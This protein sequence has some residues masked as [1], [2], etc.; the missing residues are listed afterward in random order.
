MLRFNQSYGYSKKYQDLSPVPAQQQLVQHRQQ[1]NDK[2]K[3]LCSEN[4]K[5]RRYVNNY[6]LAALKWLAAFF[7]L[8]TNTSFNLIS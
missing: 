2:T 6:I 8:D 1:I 5:R 7:E 4:K 3:K